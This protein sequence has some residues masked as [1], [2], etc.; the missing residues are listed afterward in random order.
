M[1]SLKIITNN[2][3]RHLICGY[4]LTESEKSEFDYIK[5]EDIECHEFFRYRGQLYDPSEFMRVSEQAPE[6]MKQWDG[7]S[8]DSFFS[9]IVIKY[10]EDYESVKIGLYLS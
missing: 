9:G 6:L 8:S 5:P 2:H 4:D 3:Y 1:D 10:S 7:Y